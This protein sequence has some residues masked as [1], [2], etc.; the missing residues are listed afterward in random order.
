MVFNNSALM[1]NLVPLQGRWGL[2]IQW[3]LG[4]LDKQVALRGSAVRLTR[5]S[6]ER[7]RFEPARGSVD[8]GWTKS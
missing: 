1:F 2:D 4:R 7:R 3:G 5:R 8:Y 6:H